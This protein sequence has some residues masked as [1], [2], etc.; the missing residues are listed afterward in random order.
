MVLFK[1]YKSLFLLISLLWSGVENLLYVS[2]YAGF[3]GLMGSFCK[4]QKSLWVW[5]KS[6]WVAQKSLWMWK[7]SL[8][9]AQ[10]SL[11]MWKKSLCFREKS[12]CFREKSLWFREKSLWMFQKWLLFW[13]RFAPKTNFSNFYP[14][15]SQ[16]FF[17][18]FRIKL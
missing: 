10:K 13:D 15:L 6:L 17:S 12:L 14:A 11:C 9:V 5:E 7:K 3:R 8:L 1:S 16:P 18:I 4:N 2:I